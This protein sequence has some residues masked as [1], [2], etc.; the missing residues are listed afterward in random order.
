MIHRIHLIYIT[1][2][3][4]LFVVEQFLVIVVLVMM[5]HT[6]LVMNMIMDR[7]EIIIRPIL[8]YNV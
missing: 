6:Q 7:M 5:I 8:I 3:E 1:A 2:Q 4:Q